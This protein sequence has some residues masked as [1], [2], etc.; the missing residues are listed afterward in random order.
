MKHLHQK[1][2]AAMRSKNLPEAK[3]AYKE[4]LQLNVQ[5]HTDIYTFADISI[6]LAFT[7]LEL[8]SA[9][10]AETRIKKLLKSTLPDDLYLR[11]TALY[12]RI[13]AELNNK[14]EAFSIL[15][16]LSQK[17]PLSSWPLDD[18]LYYIATEQIL[19]ENYYQ[20]HSAA[21]RLYFAALFNESAA[22]YQ[23]LLEKVEQGKYPLTYDSQ[24]KDQAKSDLYYLLSR[25]HFH[26]GNYPLV[27]NLLQTKLVDLDFKTLYL[28]ARS[29]KET[30][31]YSKQVEVLN[32][33]LKRN[34]AEAS[35]HHQEVLFE[36]GLGYFLLG[37]PSNAKPYLEKVLEKDER[38]ATIK[39]ARLYLARTYL[40]EQSYNLIP[41]LLEP[42]LAKLGAQ[43]S[44]RYELYYLLAEASFHLEFYLES[45]QQFEN[46]LPKYNK[47]K[48]EWTTIALY[49]QALC[50]LKLAKNTKLAAPTIQEYIFLAERALREAQQNNHKQKNAEIIDHTL[51]EKI[52]LSQAHAL[53]LRGSQLK[54]EHAFKD[55]ENL[56][57][58]PQLFLSLENQAEAILIRAEASSNQQKSGLYKLLTE[59]P[60]NTTFASKK[61]WYHI[62]MHAY[63]TACSLQQ[64]GDA[65]YDAL[66]LQAAS[67]L[68]KAYN[69]LKEAD[70]EMASFALMFQAESI[71]YANKGL[72]KA[73]ALSLLEELTSSKE[74][75]NASKKQDEILFFQ[76]TI[77]SELFLEDH[78][79]EILEKADFS[80]N[81]LIEKYPESLLVDKALF[82]LG[83][84]YFEGEIYDKA[85]D[86]FVRLASQHKDSTYTPQGLLLAADSAERTEGKEELA[87]TYRRQIF[88]EYSFSSYAP[89]AYFRMYSFAEYLHGDEVALQHLKEMSSLY[90]DSP[91][92]IISSYLIGL[93]Y[94]E[95]RKSLA[96]KLIHPRLAKEALIQF[97]ETTNLFNH[98]YH[99]NALP[100]DHFNYFVTTY[101]KAKL[102]HA[103]LI[104]SL[105][106]EEADENLANK[107]IQNLQSVLNDFSKPNNSLTKSLLSEC[108][109]PRV[110][111]ESEY[112]LGRLY[113]KTDQI[114]NAKKTFA[115]MQE[116]YASR[117]ITKAYYL[118]LSWYELGL[119][120][121][122]EKQYNKALENFKNVELTSSGNLLNAEQKLSLWLKKSECYRLLGNYD[123]AML[124]LSYAINENASSSLRITA[125]LLRAD[126]YA[127]QGRHELAIKQLEAV[128]KKGGDFAITAKEKL[129]VEYGFD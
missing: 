111:E 47:E 114:Q 126:I 34:A 120:D 116:K 28:L 20:V 122:K 95:E 110:C 12:A 67:N 59:T 75:F 81:Q 29:Y 87:Q 102:E 112:L 125:M 74:L 80:F 58:R 96:G 48:A 64:K 27:I 56:L 104:L 15:K 89:E 52:Y 88:E 78:E 40:K 90:K 115:K 107:A 3:D 106:D 68:S 85:E 109:F 1:A 51:E 71:Y 57:T 121:L 6:R 69:E 70:K 93:D 44:L 7:E 23:E 108:A 4:L 99:E 11:A 30:G 84:T 10:D 9:K 79:E 36:L 17:Y 37:Q 82:A 35:L 42:C 45:A 100:N 49:K 25:S 76:G 8:G 94:K 103:Q 83:T 5:A 32:E 43:D 65:H 86:C 41:P 19:T 21:K 54:S 127:L 39:L 24:A 105:L 26:A 101:Y 119:L 62:G 14:E 117:K 124:M 66:F 63:K 92:L 129:R 72:A 113:I 60:Y 46:A 123:Q 22:L 16:K 13:R 55:V 53:L 38:P 97:E 2:E 91:F 33:Y 61:A 98:F 18:R 77:A 128:T 118:A 50:Y 31:N 73:K